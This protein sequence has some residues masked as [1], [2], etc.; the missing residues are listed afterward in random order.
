MHYVRPVTMLE[1]LLLEL[2]DHSQRYP[3]SGL[4]ADVF[5]LN[6]KLFEQSV[7]K[8]RLLGQPLLIPGFEG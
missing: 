6:A 8:V 5:T 2:G 3:E 7:E 1:H 4:R